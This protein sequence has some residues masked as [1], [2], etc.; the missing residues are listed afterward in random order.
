MRREERRGRGKE[1]GRERI[2]EEG[3]DVERKGRTSG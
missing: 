1:E 3:E 2:W